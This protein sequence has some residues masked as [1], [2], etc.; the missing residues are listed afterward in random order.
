M[1]KDACLVG[2]A[3]PA[4]ANP[5]VHVVM[6]SMPT[7]P[8]P[9]VNGV[10]LVFDTCNHCVQPSDGMLLPVLIPNLDD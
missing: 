8:I 2:V 7:H 9:I 5:D 1:R 10:P 6:T 4:G 3:D